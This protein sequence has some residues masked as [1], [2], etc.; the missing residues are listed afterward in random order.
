MKRLRFRIFDCF[1]FVAC[2]LNLLGTLFQDTDHNPVDYVYSF[3]MMAV[4]LWLLARWTIEF[5]RAKSGEA[6]FD[7]ESHAL[8]AGPSLSD[9]DQSRGQEQHSK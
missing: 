2:T 5:R 6:D 4:V 3:G 9:T 8:T 7:T 1:V